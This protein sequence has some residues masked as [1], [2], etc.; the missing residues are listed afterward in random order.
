MKNPIPLKPY[1][2]GIIHTKIGAMIQGIGNERNLF[3][4]EGVG[5]STDDGITDIRFWGLIQNEIQRHFGPLKI[6]ELVA[7]PSPDG[8]E[9]NYLWLR[10][11]ADS[12]RGNADFKPTD[13]PF[14]AGST[15]RLKPKYF[16]SRSQEIIVGIA[17]LDAPSSKN[18]ALVAENRIIIAYPGNMFGLPIDSWVLQEQQN[19]PIGD[20]REYKVSQFFIDEHSDMW[21]ELITTVKETWKSIQD[22]R[23]DLS[24]DEKIPS[25]EVGYPVEVIGPKPNP[26]NTISM[27]NWKQWKWFIVP[28]PYLPL[29]GVVIQDSPPYTLGEFDMGNLIISIGRVA[30]RWLSTRTINW[31]LPYHLVPWTDPLK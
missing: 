9:N 4:D 10:E 21:P 8:S 31:Y 18:F 11:D 23:L 28:Q 7:P 13:N 12:W 22:E 5:M 14:L 20:D 2:P 16:D 30:P 15:R 27:H 26:V 17:D 19:S 3:G 6:G 25:S 29:D 24:M 1:R